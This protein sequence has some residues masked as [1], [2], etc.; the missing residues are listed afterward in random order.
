VFVTAHPGRAILI[1]LAILLPLTIPFF[2]LNL[3]QEDI[4]AT[5]KDTTERQAYDLLASGFGPGYTSPLLVAADLGTP[6]EPS[7]TFLK[8][9]KR[10]QSLQQQLEDEQ[11][12]GEAQAESLQLSAEELEAEQARLEAEKASLETQAGDLTAEKA[13][14][15]KS[16]SRLKKQ[17]K[18]LDQAEA[19]LGEAKETA[20][21]V[22]ALSREARQIAQQLK[23]NPSPELVRQLEEVR[24]ELRAEKAQAQDLKVQ[25]AD[26]RARASKAGGQAFGIASGAAS[27]AREAAGLLEE[28]DQLIQEAAAA[29]VEAAQLEVGKVQLEALQEEAKEQQAQ[30]EKLKATLTTDLT[31][32]GGDERGTDPRLLAL[33]N[34]LAGTDGVELVSPPDLNKAGDAAVF[35]VVPTTNPALPETADLVRTIRAYTIPQSTQDTDVEA[36]VGGQ[37]ASYVD[38]ADAISSKLFLVILV[39]VSLGFAVLLMAFRSILI[40]T[41]AVVAVV[42]SVCAAFGVVTA[43]FQ[44]GWGTGLVGLDVKGGDDPIASFVPLIM[45]TVLFGLSMDYQVFLMSQIEHART[46]TDGDRAAIAQG[47]ATGARVISAAAL[48]MIAVFGSFILDG[49]PTVKQFGVGL[50]VGVALAGMSVLLLAPAILVLGGSGVW[51]VPRWADRFLPHLDIEG[52]GSQGGES[53]DPRRKRGLD[54]MKL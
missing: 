52:E 17:R 16:I 10:A 49:D 43:V 48:I 12:T 25:A 32:A 21:D 27:A 7:S 51:W 26:L 53:S 15:A 30:A 42:L 47:L 31:L 14:L 54:S 44:F 40:S 28:K 19:L 39:V 1:S 18:L 36:H 9:Y 4:G 13:Q 37:T 41:Q 20:A 3:G 23:T 6:A 22:A 29:Q 50:S 35:T 45:F 2:S 33:Q 8:Q 38:L 34:A 5:P 24:Q 46:T 11:A